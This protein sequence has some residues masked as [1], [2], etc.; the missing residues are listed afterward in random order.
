M[1]DL[2]LWLPLGL[3]LLAAAVAAFLLRNR[4]ADDMGPPSWSFG[5]SWASNISVA[6]GLLTFAAAIALLKDAHDTVLTNPQYVVFSVVL[7]L[8]AAIAPLVYMCLARLENA[9]PGIRIKGWVG[10][11]ILASLFTIWGSLG[12]IILQILVIADI[13]KAAQI[14]VPAGCVVD[15]I[16]A[17][18]AAGLW[19]Y[20]VRSMI[21]AATPPQALAADRIVAAPAWTLL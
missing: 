19:C 4:L 9:N 2:V 5:T 18:L 15:G 16:L 6:G 21:V 13:C 10:T 8:I 14:P 17:L 12:Q 3:A 20:A 1:L 11:F 7:P